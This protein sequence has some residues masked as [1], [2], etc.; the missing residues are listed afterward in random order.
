MHNLKSLFIVLTLAISVMLMWAHSVQ[1]QQPLPPEPEQPEQEVIRDPELMALWRKYSYLI[2]SEQVSLEALQ[3]MITN[4][5]SEKARLLGIKVRIGKPGQPQLSG[6]SLCI[7]PIWGPG[8][9]VWKFP[10]PGQNGAKYSVLPENLYYLIWAQPPEQYVDGIY[11][12][13]WGSCVAYKI[14]DSA[15]ATFYNAESAEVCYNA[16]ACH[17]LGHCPRWVNPCDNNSPEGSWPDH[18]LR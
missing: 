17:V 4:E 11:R 18:P 13:S 16:F 1:A 2:A 15:T 8:K 14:P 7:R 5:K 12:A 3:E 9:V 10:N 6:V